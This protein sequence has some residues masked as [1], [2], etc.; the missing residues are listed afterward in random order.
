[1]LLRA[2]NVRNGAPPECLFSSLCELARDLPSVSGVDYSSIHI[3]IY[4]YINIMQQNTEQLLRQ[5]KALGDPQRL[6]LLALCRQG[7]CSVSELTHALGQSQPRVSQH[8]KQLVEVGLLGRFRDGKHVYYR[9]PASR[10]GSHRHL[11]AL[12]PDDDPQFQADAARLRD[13]RGGDL[14]AVNRELVADDA[15][16]RAL[17]R[18]ILDQ[19]V[20]APIGDLLDVGCGRGG[21]L[22]L[23]ASRANRAIGVDI[24]SNAREIAR[25]ELLLAGLPN[26]SLRK[27]DMYRL[28]FADQ[29][30]DTIILD[31]VLADAEYPVGVLL[32]A[33]RLLKPNGRMFALLDIS[34]MPSSEIQR[35][36][37]AWSV[38]A[39]LRI[40]P[41]G[42]VP[43]KN[44]SWLMSV[45]TSADNTR[46][47]A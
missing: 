12:I 23:L 18:V 33:K 7:E 41:P 37:A 9:L 32:E 25:A 13:R 5:F 26:C 19:T 15:A 2:I 35:Q 16:T 43:N 14:A 39:G 40:A 20:T 36:L 44:P 24:D 30:F 38:A 45:A 4:L 46:V 22:K 29:E 1:V 10:D 11:L 17:Q 3:K 28:P 47:A 42:L 34:R 21:I 31:D 8:V 6:R 27:G